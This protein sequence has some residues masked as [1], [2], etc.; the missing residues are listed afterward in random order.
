MSGPPFPIIQCYQFRFGF[1]NSRSDSGTGSS[2]QLAG[3]QGLFATAVGRARL[4]D[5]L[6]LNLYDD[7]VEGYYG[8]TIRQPY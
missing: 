3:F 6:R 5:T 1:P 2:S 7:C 8:T 4:L